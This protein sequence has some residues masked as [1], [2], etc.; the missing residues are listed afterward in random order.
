M[1]CLGISI[2]LFAQSENVTSYTLEDYTEDLEVLHSILDNKHPNINEYLTPQEIA[3][4]REQSLSTLTKEPTF[5]NFIKALDYVGDGHLSYSLTD[6]IVDEKIREYLYFPLGIYFNNGK[7][8][9]NA[10]DQELPYGTEITHINN[11]PIDEILAYLNKYIS[12][13]GFNKS[14]T[15]AYS[16]NMFFIN[17]AYF[18][19]QQPTQFSIKYNELKTGKN[20]VIKLNSI[21]YYEA[22]DIAK[23]LVYPINYYEK[24][25]SIYGRYYTDKKVGV[26]TVN[27]FDLSE[28]YAYKKFSEFFKKMNQEKYNDVIIDIRNNFGGDPNISALLF[29]FLT[30]TTFKHNFNYK[31]KSIK[32]KKE[33]LVDENRS[34]FKNELID[35]YE[36]YLYQRF[37]TLNNEYVG[38]ERLFDNLVR[39]YPNDKDN[40]TGNVYVLV[41]GKTFSAAVYFADIFD[42]HHRGEI[43]GRNTG[44]DKNQTFA[45]MFI[46]YELPNTKILVRLPLFKLMFSNQDVPMGPL[47]PTITIPEKDFERYFKLKQ[48]ADMQFIF[49]NLIHHKN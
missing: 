47:K 38:N 27:S 46:F 6:E 2:Q 12:G 11:Q 18:F 3:K 20:K 36:N 37:D 14:N 15:E 21:S 4:K 44:G 26:L 33:Y 9:V 42:R 10:T 43:I 25:Q 35:D 29:S 7:M 40:Y 39:N 30:D 45:G 32:L 22:Y 8:Y 28:T 19:E 13:D 16:S 31:M 5:N 17:Y 23:K 1:I 49:D 41:G 34:P 48:D 24:E